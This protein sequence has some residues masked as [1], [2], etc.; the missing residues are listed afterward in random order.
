MTMML[1]IALA[2]VA[3]VGCD[4]PPTRTEMDELR[5]QVK[6]MAQTIEDLDQKVISLE[7]D[8]EEAKNTCEEN[9][10][11]CPSPGITYTFPTVRKPKKP[12]K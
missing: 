8:L 10:C 9:A 12:K 11:D 4:K 5:W 3:L 6:A 7:S 2:F 1:A